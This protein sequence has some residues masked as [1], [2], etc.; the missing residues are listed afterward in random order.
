MP[1]HPARKRGDDRQSGDDVAVEP[2]E[3]RPEVLTPGR[4]LRRFVFRDRPR[5]YRPIAS[6]VA[7]IHDLTRHSSGNGIQQVRV[8]SQPRRCD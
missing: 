2:V 3:R 7:D 6:R 1:I 8:H 5:T 4:R